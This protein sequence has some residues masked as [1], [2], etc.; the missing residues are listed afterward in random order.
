M[1]APCD[2]YEGCFTES[3]QMSYFLSLI[4]SGQTEFAFL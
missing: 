3:A 1:Y 2:D 4:R